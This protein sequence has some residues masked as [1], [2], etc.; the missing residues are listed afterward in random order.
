[1]YA[2]EASLG[3]LGTHT[4]ISSEPEGYISDLVFG[5]DNEPRAVLR[6]DVNGGAI[7]VQ[8]SNGVWNTPM[9]IVT[10]IFDER[11][12]VIAIGPNQKPAVLWYESGNGANGKLIDIIT[13]GDS[14]SSADVTVPPFPVSPNDLRRPFGIKVGMDGKKRIVISGPGSGDDQ[15]WFGIED[16]VGSGSFSWEQ[17][18]ASNIYADQIGFTLDENDY[19]YITCKDFTLGHPNATCALFENSSGSWVKHNFSGIPD[20]NRSAPAVD[21][22]GK[23]WVAQNAYAYNH[24]YLW[25]NRSGSWKEEQVITNN[26]AIETISGFGFTD[27]NVMKIAYTPTVDSSDLV[28]MYNTKFE[29]PEPGILISGILFILLSIKRRI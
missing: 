29:I 22:D 11:R 9:M 2:E 26:L 15:L 8:R 21:V 19:A 10:N 5:S 6:Y 24:F 7:Y 16:T 23:I 1:M 28:Y 3:T 25:S 20:W 17:I 18:A 4:A 13:A 14:Y 12:A 27:K